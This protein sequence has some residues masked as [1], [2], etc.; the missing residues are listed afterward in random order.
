MATAEADLL[1]RRFRAL[2]DE[3]RRRI[4]EL[5]GGRPGATTAEI[6]AGVPR[7]S[8]WAVMKHIAGLRDADLVQTL[9][10]GRQRCH[11]RVERGLDE[12][13]AWLRA[14]TDPA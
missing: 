7:L 10:R 12:I 9:P 13:R 6:A 4:W 11:Y 5:L 2:A 3:T 8:R 14:A 1:D